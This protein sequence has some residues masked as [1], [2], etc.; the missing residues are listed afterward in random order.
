M[1]LALGIASIVVGLVGTLVKRERFENLFK[2]SNAQR[3]SRAYTEEDID[4]RVRLVKIAG[5]I[6]LV[7]GVLLVAMELSIW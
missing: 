6:G 4:K 3:G 7:S 5:P 2:D 1:V